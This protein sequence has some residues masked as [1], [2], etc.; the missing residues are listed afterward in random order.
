[1]TNRRRLAVAGV[2]LLTA[3]SSAT[4]FID[5]WWLYV[6]GPTHHGAIPDPGMAGRLALAGSALVSVISGLI[7]RARRPDNP[8][9]IWLI[10]SGLCGPLAFMVDHIVSPMRVV[11]QMNQA[12][13]RRGRM[14]V[15][16][17]RVTGREQH[18]IAV[19]EADG[20]GFSFDLQIGATRANDVKHTIPA[21]SKVIPPWGHQLSA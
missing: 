10:V 9:G 12:G 7:A 17:V 20:P 21:D 3:L 2:L 4:V 14:V 6:A 18:K 16:R 13:E 1:M 5:G 15:E 11:V 8:I 19:F